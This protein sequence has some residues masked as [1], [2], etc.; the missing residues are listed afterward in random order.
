MTFTPNENEAVDIGNPNLAPQEVESF[1]VSAE[2]YFAPSAL[3]SVGYFRK[4]RTNLFSSQTDFALTNNNTRETNPSC[5]GGGVFNPLAATNSFLPAN[6]VGICVDADT[7]LNDPE[8]L[9]QEG[10]E[11]SLQYDLSSWEDRIG[12]ASGFGVL[13]NYTYQDFSGGSITNGSATRGTDI[14]NAINGIFDERDFVQVT[15][16]QGLLDN[17][18]NAFNVTGYYEKFGLSARLRYTWR[19][20]FRT[21]DTAAGASRNST[22]G[23]PVVTAARGQLN[24]SISYDI[25]D[26]FTVGVEGVNITKS[27]I[28]QSC[29]NDGALL[30]FQG[31]ADRR[32]TFG[33]SY[34]F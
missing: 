12:W 33:G 5:P 24:G 7:I 28:E 29:V 19:D 21:D 11:V 34:T 1:D 32:I 23:F 30:C 14:F 26:H 15:A 4:E 17:S 13:A 2:W 27:G 20:A 18:E 9:T 10:V 3:F 8:T 16:L 6:T 22:L 31:I 25:T